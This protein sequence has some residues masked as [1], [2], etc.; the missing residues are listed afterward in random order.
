MSENKNTEPA[1]PLPPD[2]NPT[3]ISTC[4]LTKRELGAMF[5]MMGLLSRGY[6]DPADAHYAVTSADALLAELAK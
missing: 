2:K 6:P 4:G 1:F 5:A 3:F